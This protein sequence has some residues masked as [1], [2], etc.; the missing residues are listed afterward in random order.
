MTGSTS[1]ACLLGLDVGGRKIGVSVADTTLS[2][3]RPLTRIDRPPI[4]RQQQQEQPQ[5]GQESFPAFFGKE[6]NKLIKTHNVAG[7]VVGYP[8]TLWE[9]KEGVRCQE[10]VKFMS[11]VYLESVQ[12]VHVPFAVWDERMTTQV[13]R[14]ALRGEGEGLG[15]G[16]GEGG[17][18]R[19]RKKGEGRRQEVEDAVAATIILQGF[20]ERHIRP[21]IA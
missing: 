20:L 18:K 3:A 1:T 13:A 15:E 14:E 16:G 11:C 12:E 9:G 8:L 10:V 17:G 21:S 7:L 19:R 6:L 5:Q 4:R 2:I